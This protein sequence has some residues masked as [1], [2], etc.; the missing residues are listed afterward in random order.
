M[1]R[2]IAGLLFCLAPLGL[3]VSPAAAEEVIVERVQSTSLSF[4]GGRNYT[5]AKLEVFGPDN[6]LKEETATR[7]LP[8]FRLQTAGRLVDGYYSYTLRAAT[9]EEVPVDTSIDNGRGDAARSTMKKPFAMYGRF[10]VEQGLMK[11]VD[12]SETEG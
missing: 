12:D 10:L 7:G 5:N 8:I 1:K 3:A 6:Y 2:L 4:E 9:D 11:P